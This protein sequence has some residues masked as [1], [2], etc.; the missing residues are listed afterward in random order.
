MKEAWSSPTC[1]EIL[2]EPELRIANLINISATNSK[3]RLKLRLAN[4][5]SM[6]NSAMML[7]LLVVVFVFPSH[8]TD[9]FALL[10]S[11]L[12]ALLLCV[13]LER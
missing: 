10:L 8:L 5:E 6:M 12:L 7:L 13:P 9:R 1:C 3:E 2:T 4:D 11:L